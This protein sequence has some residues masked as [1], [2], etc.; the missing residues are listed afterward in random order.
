M[1]SACCEFFAERSILKRLS[2]AIPPFVNRHST[3]VI[4]RG[5]RREY[6]NYGISG[7]LPSG[8]LQPAFVNGVAGN[9]RAG[10]QAF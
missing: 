3:F 2:E 10:S 5:F 9:L 1:Y 4:H 6:G 8:R 7:L